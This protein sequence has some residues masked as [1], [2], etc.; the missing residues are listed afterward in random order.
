MNSHRIA[1]FLGVLSCLGAC[2]SEPADPAY[3]PGTKILELNDRTCTGAAFHPAGKKLLIALGKDGL[4][5]WSSGSEPVPV[6]VKVKEARSFAHP[7]FSSDG[8]WGAAAVDK[9][10]FFSRFP[11]RF[12]HL[13]GHR[14]EALIFPV[15]QD[16]S[17]PTHRFS[18]P[19]G[20]SRH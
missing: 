3:D 17:G 6:P 8:T 15:P 1:L 16:W 12:A 14:M 11:D 19:S 7:I 5:T 2:S 10:P 9:L 18:K 4:V 13:P 20:Q